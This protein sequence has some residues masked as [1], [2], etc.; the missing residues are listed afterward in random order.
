ML[1]C[2]QLCKLRDC[3][4]PG[5]SVHGDSRGKN[6]R[7]WSHSLLQVIFLTQGSN[8]GLSHCRQILYHLSHKGNPDEPILFQI[9][10]PLRLLHK[11]S[12]LCY[13]VGPCWLSILNIVECTC[14]S[15]TP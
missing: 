1:G 9:C 13:V 4:P 14:P 5:S 7:M 8:L 3:S 6:P 10:F 11:Q 15:Q 12:S 2:V